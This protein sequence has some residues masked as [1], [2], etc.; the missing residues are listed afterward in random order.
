M[1]W[2]PIETAPRDGT[3]VLLYS[4]HLVVSGRFADEGR[5]TKW[6]GDYGGPLSGPL[7]P[8][9]WQPKPGAPR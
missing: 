7:A 2:Q 5:G 4:P 3:A 9:H 6:Y 1:D 8:T